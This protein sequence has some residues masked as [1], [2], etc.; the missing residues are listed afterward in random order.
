MAHEITIRENGFAEM[1]FIGSRSN[2]WHT[3][4]QELTP[5]APIDVWK[6][7]AGCDWLALESP[8][9]YSVVN[10]LNVED[11]IFTGKKALFRSDTFAQLAV[12]GEDFKVL[13]PG[14]VLE[15][16]RD[17]TEEHGMVMSTAGTL[18][19]GTRFW[20]LAETGKKFEAM[21]GDEVLGHLLLV[22][23]LD[24]SLA[25]TAKFVSTRVVCN[26]T[27]SIAMHGAS[28]SLVKKT[29][30]TVFDSTAAKIDLGLIDSGWNRFMDEINALVNRKMSVEEVKG[31]YEEMIFDP[32][33][34]PNVQSWGT[35]RK[36]NRLMDLYLD[37]AGAEEARGTAWGALNAVTNFHT[38]GTGKRNASNQ[39]WDSYFGK[40]DKFKNL[41][42]D[43]LLEMC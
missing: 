22:T 4:G 31:F 25:T 8:V 41:V 12:V 14:E 9:K 18:F 24:G 36:V 10:G 33:V 21:M 35:V 11:R 20:A 15:F 32:E 13:H 5:G 42:L 28:T 1:A 30:H 3:L 37:G 27:L 39:F 19:G 26:N 2:I 34:D 17:L 6:T 16:F 43:E 40:D 38:H 29:H 23:A 7:E